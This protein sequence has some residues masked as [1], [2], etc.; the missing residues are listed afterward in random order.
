M[1]GRKIDGFRQRPAPGGLSIYLP[2]ARGEE[3]QEREL[4]PQYGN[5]AFSDTAWPDLVCRLYEREP[6]KAFSETRARR[7][8][9]RGATGSEATGGSEQPDGPTRTEL[10]EAFLAVVNAFTPEATIVALPPMRTS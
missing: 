1:I 6:P 8:Q 9:A 4:S 7:T 5:L 10:I 2:L 3:G